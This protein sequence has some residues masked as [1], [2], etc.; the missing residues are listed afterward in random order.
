M[1]QRNLTYATHPD[2]GSS[3]STTLFQYRPVPERSTISERESLSEMLYV[4]L[5][6]SDKVAAWICPLVTLV[7]EQYTLPVH[8]SRLHVLSA[9]YWPFVSHA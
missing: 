2:P 9:N 3:F 7:T 5:L 1:Y 8:Q 6:R 4:S